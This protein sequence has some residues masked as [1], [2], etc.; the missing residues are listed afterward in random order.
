[1]SD[2]CVRVKRQHPVN[3]TQPCSEDRHDRDIL[4]LE[5]LLCC[6]A[7]RRLD[8]H[9]HQRKIAGRLITHERDDLLGKL[10]EFLVVCLR[11]SHQSDLVL[12]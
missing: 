8:L 10:S 2:L 11:L 9:V 3:K 12:N 6:L 1:M 7:D 4:A 5:H